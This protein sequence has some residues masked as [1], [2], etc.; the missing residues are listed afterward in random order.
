MEAVV[1]YGCGFQAGFKVS[2]ICSCLIQGFCSLGELRIRLQS[3]SGVS[4]D[5]FFHD[6]LQ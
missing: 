6:R 5:G 4:C 2:L 3:P 1:R